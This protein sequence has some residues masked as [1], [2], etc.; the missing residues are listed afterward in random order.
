MGADHDRIGASTSGR[1]P[2]P[3]TDLSLAIRSD[4]PLS[5]PFSLLAK[6]GAQWYNVGNV[7]R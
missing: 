7:G 6:P 3:I 4:Y 2:S 1:R 5:F